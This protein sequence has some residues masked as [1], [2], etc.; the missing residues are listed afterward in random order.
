MTTRAAERKRGAE[1]RAEL[2]EADL[3]EL[4]QELL[5]EVAELDESWAAKAEAIDTVAVRL[6]A[7]DVR[8]VE[9][10]LVWVLSP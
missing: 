1:E 2:A 6:E 10:A 3:E 7:T 5:D 4:E 8:V 9:T